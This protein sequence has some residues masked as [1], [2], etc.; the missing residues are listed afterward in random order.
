MSNEVGMDGAAAG[1]VGI[2]LAGGR[3][4]AFALAD[5]V[6]LMDGRTGGT[7]VDTPGTKGL[8]S[9]LSGRPEEDNGHKYQMTQILTKERV[10]QTK[11]LLSKVLGT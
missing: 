9:A 2:D 8:T 5:D 11:L 6:A 1:I 10:T 3:T 4:G 7:E